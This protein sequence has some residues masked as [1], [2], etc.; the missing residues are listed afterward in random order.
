MQRDNPKCQ[1]CEKEVPYL[2]CPAADGELCVVASIP[3]FNVVTIQAAPEGI[4]L[5]K[6]L[7][8]MF[9]AEIERLIT[10]IRIYDKH[11]MFW[12]NVSHPRISQQEKAYELGRNKQ[13]VD[14][15]SVRLSQTRKMKYEMMQ[16]AYK[17]THRV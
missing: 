12:T 6:E 16:V 2:P 15:A 14:D 7:R 10:M 1:A 8:T 3:Q 9:N 11:R 17:R 5:E 4:S 13:L